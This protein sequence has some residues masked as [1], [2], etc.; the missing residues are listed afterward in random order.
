[1]PVADNATDDGRE[2]NRRVELK[3]TESAGGGVT[4]EPANVVPAA[5]AIP[6]AERSSGTGGS[7]AC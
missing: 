2:L 7:R 5:D 3:I 6:A 1:M 4:A